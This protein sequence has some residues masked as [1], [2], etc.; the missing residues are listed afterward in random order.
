[1]NKTQIMKKIVKIAGNML[2]YAFIALCIFGVVLTIIAKRDSDST[3]TVF[4]KQ[5]RSVLS[6][7]MER[8]DATDVSSY[9]IKD[10]PVGSII[11]IDVVPKDA[12]EAE[13]WYAALE[14]GDVLTFKYVY[15]QQETITHRITDITANA[16]G[17]YTIKLEGDNKNVDANVLTQVIHTSEKNSPNY[18]I[19]KVTGQSY[20]LGLFINTLKS[21]AGLIFVVILPSLL[22]IILEIL[23]IVRLFYI[24]R[25][26]A[27]KELQQH[28]L[29][30]LRRRL[31]ELQAL[32]PAETDAPE[33][34]APTSPSGTANGPPV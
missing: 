2:L 16:D 17:G 20:I 8:C 21:P 24:K 23:K 34:A 1:M 22:I 12:K 5:M 6:P 18:V 27:E 7:S 14:V 19:G 26:A 29:E 10:I 9:Q 11:F 33:G 25:D 31:A 28:E 30:S 15:V 4:G 3:A 13:K 32:E